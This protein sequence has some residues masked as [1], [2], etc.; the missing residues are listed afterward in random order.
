LRVAGSGLGVEE[1]LLIFED[2]ELKVKGLR[3]RV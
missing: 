2:L 3:F 1:L